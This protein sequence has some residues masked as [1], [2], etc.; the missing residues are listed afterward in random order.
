MNDDGVRTCVLLLTVTVL[1]ERSAAANRC[2]HHLDLDIVFSCFPLMGAMACC[3][4]SCS[5]FSGFFCSRS[6]HTC[7]P[8]HQWFSCYHIWSPSKNNRFLASLLHMAWPASCPFSR[9]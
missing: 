4:C 5:V 1:N 6:S 7:V 8:Q 3:W 2:P 9:R